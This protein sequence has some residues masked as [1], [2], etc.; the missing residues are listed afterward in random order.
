MTKS[1]FTS[2]RRRLG[3]G[4]ECS[5][6]RVAFLRTTNPKRE[7]ILVDEAVGIALDQAGN[8]L[9][10]LG[11]L[12]FDRVQTRVNLGSCQAPLVFVL[13]AIPGIAS[14]LLAL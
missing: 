7:L 2:L 4:P 6:S 3:L 9:L 11:N 14:L 12:R 13:N 10:D 5:S 1:R 8:G